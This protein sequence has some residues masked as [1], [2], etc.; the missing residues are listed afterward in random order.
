MPAAC[1]LDLRERVVVTAGE[2]A[3]RRRAAGVFKVSVSTAIRWSK[4][5]ASTGRCARLPSG[6]D[7][8]SKSIE[9]HKDWL[10]FRPGPT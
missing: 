1:S 6:G 7:N 8:R 3:S 9:E 2:G 4:R 5:L 10:W